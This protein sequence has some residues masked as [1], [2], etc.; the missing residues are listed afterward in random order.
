MQ[1]PQLS[2]GIERN[3]ARPSSAGGGHSDAVPDQLCQQLLG[4]PKDA[5]RSSQ[6]APAMPNMSIDEA[7]QRALEAILK[8]RTPLKA[9][10]T[11][12]SRSPCAVLTMTLTCVR[13]EV[14]LI[15]SH[16]C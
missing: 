10:A 16:S 15:A 5:P 13:K 14:R 11:Q 3:M 4:L 8:V 2:M 9:R 7:R 12:S 1:T 6:L